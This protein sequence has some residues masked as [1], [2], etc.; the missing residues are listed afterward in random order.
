MKTDKQGCST[1]QPG[2]EQ[3]EEFYSSMSQGWR[4]QY[5]YRTPE[6]K[7]FSCVAKSLEAARAK[8]DE[9]FEEKAQ[10]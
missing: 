4:V 5:D 1:A 8:R 9:W 3:Y 6:G 2:K 10:S 7:L